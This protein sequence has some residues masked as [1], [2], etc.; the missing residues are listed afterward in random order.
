MCVDINVVLTILQ[1][2]IGQFV[3]KVLLPRMETSGASQELYW[4]LQVFS[5]ICKDSTLLLDL[6]VNYDCDVDQENVFQRY[7][8]PFQITTKIRINCL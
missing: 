6:Y 2:E 7:L 8:K 1:D 3:V 4:V 5:Q